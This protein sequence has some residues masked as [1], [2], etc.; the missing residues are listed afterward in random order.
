[1]GEKKRTNGEGSIYQRKDGRYVGQYEVEGKR[2]YI[3]GSDKNEVRT[4]L[5]KA[6]ADR[7]AG[8]VWDSQDLTVGEY[9]SVWL[10]SIRDTVGPRTWKRHEEIKRLHIE[11]T[12]GKIRLDKLNPLQVQS[13]YRKKLNEG[14]SATTVRKTH[15]TLYKALKQAVRWQ[16]L[17]RNVCESVTPPRE[18]RPEIIAL[19][20][21][22]VKCLLFAAKDDPLYAFYVLAC[23]TGMRQGELLALRWEYVDFNAG[24]IQVRRTVWQGKVY[25]PKTP[26]SRRTVR[27]SQIAIR[28][29][30]DHRQKQTPDTEWRFPNRAGQPMDCHNFIY[31]EW[32]QLVKKAGLSDKTK[33]HDLRHTAAT[34]L[35]TK[36]V[37]PKIVQELLGHSSISITLDTYS[38]V[39]PNMQGEAVKAMDSFFEDD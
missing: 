15:I 18:Q 11:P 3:Y 14:R 2:R 4:K 7:D 16:L 1:M 36:G 20:E 34:L 31:R 27:L 10:D 29:L 35:L 25:P 6:L 19:T 39:L 30:W 17:P 12:L 23:T 28:A 5:T 8:L 21:E 37:H 24:T 26:R 9:L 22:E 13:L 38:H 32:K 33:F